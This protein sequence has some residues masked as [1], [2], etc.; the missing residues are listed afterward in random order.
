M[1]SYANQ[2]DLFYSCYLY[3]KG[4]TKYIYKLLFF[5]NRKD[6]YLEY[7]K[8]VIIKDVSVTSY[9]GMCYYVCVLSMEKI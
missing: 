7:H 2:V 8:S 9:K 3:G 1:F 4:L 5:F 6:I